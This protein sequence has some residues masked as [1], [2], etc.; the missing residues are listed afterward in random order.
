MSEEFM[1]DVINDGAMS[2]MVRGITAMERARQEQISRMPANLWNPRLPPATVNA[3]DDE[4]NDRS[5]SAYWTE[6]DP[7]NRLTVTEGKYGL[8]LE[9]ANPNAAHEVTGIYKTLP[10]GDFTMFTRCAPL[11]PCSGGG[12]TYV[13]LALW[14]NPTDVSKKIFTFGIRRLN[15]QYYLCCYEWTNTTTVGTTKIVEHTPTQLADSMFW[16]M[17]RNGTNYY[18]DYSVGGIGWI[19]GNTCAAITLSFTPVAMGIHMNAYWVTSGEKAQV[20][21]FRYLGSDVGF[22]GILEGNRM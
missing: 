21:F 12:Y 11:S 7:N 16:R 3:Y 14:E 4:F 1:K 10:A 15:T 2:R 5:F 6:A 9:Q 22:T 20:D 17:R 13:G 18:V 19:S 8:L